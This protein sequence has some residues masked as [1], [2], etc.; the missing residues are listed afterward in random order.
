M[1]HANLTNISTFFVRR[2]YA[3][4]RLSI[5]QCTEALIKAKEA[6]HASEGQY[7]DEDMLRMGLADVVHYLTRTNPTRHGYSGP[8][9]GGPW[10][11]PHFGNAAVEAYYKI[12]AED[13]SE[14]GR[15]LQALAR[16]ETPTPD[17]LL[18]YADQLD[19]S[20]F[21]VLAQRMR[22]EAMQRK[23][24]HNYMEDDEVDDEEWFYEAFD[25]IDWYYAPGKRNTYP[26]GI[27][28]L[29]NVTH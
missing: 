18:V 8:A 9:K 25:N 24:W 3:K 17:Y 2:L 7:E 19:E 22:T 15:K 28:I 10:I 1:G 11:I 12:P 13:L 29:S 16:N 26:D 14:T 6:L 23:A 27:P 4:G 20:G 5:F 21:D